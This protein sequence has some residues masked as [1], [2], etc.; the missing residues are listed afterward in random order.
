MYVYFSLIFLSLQV[1]EEMIDCLD[2]DWDPEAHDRLVAKLFNDDYYGASTA[3]DA[4]DEAPKV[5][6]D[7][8]DAAFMQTLDSGDYDDYLPRQVCW[9][10]ISVV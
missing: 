9:E 7:E 6:S 8:E 2:T 1:K 10:T 3:D 5:E 4:L